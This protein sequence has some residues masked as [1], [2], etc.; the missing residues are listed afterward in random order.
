MIQIRK[1]FYCGLPMRNGDVTKAECLSWL[2]LQQGQ[3]HSTQLLR[4]MLET[5]EHLLTRSDGGSDSPSNIVL[6]HQYCNSSRGDRTA[7]QHKRW[8]RQLLAEGGHPLGQLRGRKK[9]T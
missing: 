5:K 3:P 8:I 9:I 4:Y 1:C 2:S 7:E 6:A